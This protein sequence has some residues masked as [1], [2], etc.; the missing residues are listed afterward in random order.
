MQITILLI[1][2]DNCFFANAFILSCFRI[3]LFNECFPRRILRSNRL[4]AAYARNKSENEMVVRFKTHKVAFASDK[5]NANKFDI[6]LG[7]C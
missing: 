5:D 4:H 6:S 1:E 3:K 7:M 2:V